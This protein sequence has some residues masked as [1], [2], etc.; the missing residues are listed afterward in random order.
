MDTLEEDCLAKDGLEGVLNVSTD[1]SSLFTV[2]PARNPANLSAVVLVSRSIFGGGFMEDALECNVALVEVDGT[3][4]ST[5]SWSSR[6]EPPY[7]SSESS[8]RVV[9]LLLRGREVWGNAS[10]SPDDSSSGVRTV[11]RLFDLAEDPSGVDLVGVAMIGLVRRTGEE[12]GTGEIGASFDGVFLKN[13]ARVDCLGTFFADDM[14]A[15]LLSIAEDGRVV[16][17]A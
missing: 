17:G 14:T 10:S 5:R 2:L 9:F 16:R 15:R 3:S 8:R 13:E 7:S 11:W 12:V 6:K 1:S 4:P